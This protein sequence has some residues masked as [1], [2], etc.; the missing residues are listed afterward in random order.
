LFQSLASELVSP[1]ILIYYSSEVYKAARDF[2]ASIAT[3]YRLSTKK[4]KKLDQKY[5]IPSLN[6]LLK[7]KTKLRK[8]WQEIRYPKCKKV[9]NWVTQNIRRMVR[10]S[11]LE[12]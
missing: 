1:N 10:K 5:E 9:M 7:H 6:R 8:E 12:R 11:A 2:A 4:S 3:S